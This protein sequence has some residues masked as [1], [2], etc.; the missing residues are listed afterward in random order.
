MVGGSADYAL[1]SLVHVN[2]GVDYTHYGY[3]Q[4]PPQIFGILEPASRTS[5]L[6]V[7]LGLG[8]AFGGDRDYQPFK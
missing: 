7:R 4:S 1:N 2:A 3:G 8:I 6:T 5:S